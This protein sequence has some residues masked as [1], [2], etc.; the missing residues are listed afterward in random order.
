MIY[1]TQENAQ[2]FYEKLLSEGKGMET[3]HKY[4]RDLSKLAEFLS[5]AALT[6]EKLEEYKNW[7]VDIKGYKPRSANSFLS[8]ANK[9]CKVM[10]QNIHIQAYKLKYTKCNVVSGQ[11]SIEEY[12]RLTKTAVE[13]KDSMLALVMQVLSMTDIRV[14]ELFWITVESLETGNIEVPRKGEI[15]KVKLPMEILADLRQYVQYKEYRSGTVFRTSRGNPVDR[16]QLWKKLKGLC[17]LAGVDEEKVSFQN[18]KRP[19]E[20]EYFPL[21]I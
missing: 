4:Q 8:C 18:L 7:L 1:V 16:F 2:I 19:L 17:S 9:F 12:K 20:R 14:T 11:L 6:Q 10:G 21:E 5:G 15:V 3:V 13:N